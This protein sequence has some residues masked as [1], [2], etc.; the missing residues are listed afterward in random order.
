MHFSLRLILMLL[1]SSTLYSVLIVIS[2][3]VSVK[4]L[5]SFFHVFYHE[6]F[7][8]SFRKFKIELSLF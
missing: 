3:F 4:T 5:F 2:F 8:G 1:V 6:P 7:Y